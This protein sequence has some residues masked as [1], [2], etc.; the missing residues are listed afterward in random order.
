M[1]EKGKTNG[2]VR[3]EVW[4]REPVGRKHSTKSNGETIGNKS[5]T[6]GKTE[7]IEATTYSKIGKEVYMCIYTYMCVYTYIY[8]IYLFYSILRSRNVQKTTWETT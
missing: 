4:Y 3:R 5:S 6:S 8:I 7:G 1:E 2:R